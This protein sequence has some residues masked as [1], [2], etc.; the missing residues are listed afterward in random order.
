M[1]YNP[2]NLDSYMRMRK[3]VERISKVLG[4]QNPLEGGSE[5]APC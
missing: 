1:D 2:P 5:I 3:S 4:L